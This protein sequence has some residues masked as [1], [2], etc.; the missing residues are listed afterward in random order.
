M[1]QAI[2]G[3]IILDVRVSF[4]SWAQKIEHQL[5]LRRI[6]FNSL[7]K[8]KTIYQERKRRI[9]TIKR[10][11]LQDGMPRFQMSL[12]L[13]FTGLAGFLASFSLL[14]LSV[15][16]M[17]IRYPIAILIAYGVF[18]LLLR[19]WLWMYGRE[20]DVELDPDLADVVLE[21]PSGGSGSS[22]VPHF[23]AVADVGDCHAV[24]SLGESVA[25][26]AGSSSSSFWSAID[27]DLDLDEGWFL[28]IA[29]VLVIGLLIVSLYII[30]IAPLLL[31]EILIDGVLLMGLYKR[32]KYIDQGHWLRA[33]V[34]RT[35]IP[36]LVIALLF[37]VAGFAMQRV[38]P[39]A[40]SIGSFWKNI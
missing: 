6:S 14:H 21:L 26:S 36:A 16:R 37:S 12:I 39:E 31:A 19:L 4:H 10:R 5:T 25:S 1:W 28:V 2:A 9:E 40:Q 22:E 35:I 3:R 17:W 33:A 34:R 20:M 18:L 30:Y 8:P 15:S 29:I 27:F 23:N 7:M 11:L 13:L 32:V 24:G 38:V